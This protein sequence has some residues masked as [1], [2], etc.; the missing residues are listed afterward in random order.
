MG[1]QKAFRPS[2]VLPTRSTGLLKIGDQAPPRIRLPIVARVTVRQWYAL[3]VY[4][5]REAKAKAWLAERGIYAFFPTV[6]R[7]RVSRG[8]QITRERAELPGLLF[9]GFPG[10]P[11][12]HR[13]FGSPYVRDALRTSSGAPGILHPDTLV[14]L[15]D[16][17]SRSDRLEEQRLDAANIRPGCKARVI[18]GPFADWQVDVVQITTEGTA[19]FTIKLLGGVLTEI[20][21]DKLERIN[22]HVHRAASQAGA[23]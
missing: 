3:R 9:A 22:G 7:Y 11:V 17:R 2:R 13:L 19:M 10:A 20:G 6:A 18:A 15:K 21:I 4:P 23:G 8:R 12:W 14:R 5:R 16:M 1:S